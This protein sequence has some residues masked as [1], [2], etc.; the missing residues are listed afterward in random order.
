MRYSQNSRHTGSRGPGSPELEKLAKLCWPLPLAALALAAYVYLSA[1]S[2]PESRLH[3]L[4]QAV[5]ALEVD[6]ARW[7]AAASAQ[8]ASPPDGS[9]TLDAT[10]SALD[11]SRAELRA[12]AS[13]LQLDPAAQQ[14]L[15]TL[16]ANVDRLRAGI[17]QRPRANSAPLLQSIAAAKAQLDRLRA[18]TR[19]HS[20]RLNTLAYLLC[21]AF[22][23]YAL[24]AHL[25]LRRT[26]SDLKQRE[27]ERERSRRRAE[28]SL[29]ESEERLRHV[30]ESVN[31]F[32]WETDPQA[33]FTFVSERCQLVRGYT[34]AQM[35]GQSPYDYIVDDDREQVRAEIAAAVEAHRP[36][37]IE[38]RIRCQSGEV[39]WE[40]ITGTPRFDANGQYL[41]CRGAC[42]DISARKR[43]EQQ[44][45]LMMDS[46]PAAII[47]VDREEVFRQVNNT[48]MHWFP[49]CGLPIGK[50]VATC[51]SAE[52]YA[53]LAEHIRGVLDGQPQSFDAPTQVRG[54]WRILH[55]DYI[56][57]EASGQGV[58]GY[59]GMLTDVT[60][61]RRASQMLARQK[62]MLERAEALSSVGSWRWEVGDDSFSVSPESCRILG[63]PPVERCANA[64]AA[65]LFHP[66]DQPRVR[67]SARDCLKS[68]CEQTLQVRILRHGEQRHLF[69]HFKAERSGDA[70]GRERTTAIAGLMRD[71]TEEKR[72]ER[73]EAR[74][75]DI[76]EQVPGGIYQLHID[77]AGNPQLPYL[78]RGAER[79]LGYPVEVLQQYP[80][81]LFDAVHPD[82]VSRV[83]ASTE[84]SSRELTPFHEQIRMRRKDGG[85]SWIEATGVPARQADGSTLSTGYMQD[86]TERKQL[87]AELE[88]AQQRLHE[89]IESMPGGF[90]LYDADDRLVIWNRAQK[91]I[92]NPTGF[93]YYR[94]M[95][96]EELVRYAVNHPQGYGYF[97]DEAESERFVA[98]RLSGH[99]TA[100]FSQEIRLADGRW[101]WVRE[102]ATREGGVVGIRTDISA[103]KNAEDEL[104]EHRDNL[105]QLV[106]ARS[107][108]LLRAKE[109]AERANQL[110]SEFLA[111][112]SHELRTPM[113]AILS[114]AGMGDKRAARA[115][116][117]KLGHYFRRIGESGERLLALLN[118][119]LDLSKLEA[120]QMHMDFAEENFRN[121]VQT[122]LEEFSALL[123]R[124][125]IQIHCHNRL[126]DAQLR[127]DGIRIQQVVRNLLSNAVKFSPDGGAIDVLLE[128]CGA[129]ADDSG[130]AGQDNLACSVRD[131]GP[132]IPSGE[133]DLVFDEFVQSSNTRTGAGGTGLGLAICRKIVHLHGG[134]IG[135]VNRDG[136]GA[137]FTFCLPRRGPQ[138]EQSGPPPC[139]DADTDADADADAAGCPLRHGD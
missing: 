81:Q 115:E 16:Q 44:M 68:G 35:L 42:E 134:G 2:P 27:R 90:M 121:L 15:Q 107:A 23:G 10:R 9:A 57:H 70:A 88:L 94:G 12:A 93:N 28:A 19:Q 113:H 22:G 79:L 83:R 67:S 101:I 60:E 76:T 20:R 99:R 105:Q 5:H 112:I 100:D 43:A 45:Q 62:Q 3:R 58:I 26:T 21:A 13:D 46:V 98:Q 127:C 84:C 53:M 135:A 31:E 125:D 48:W 17:G 66:D 139:A 71:I 65:A 51:T 86:I 103:Q 14:A 123:S 122:V 96:F 33:R 124:R 29:R 138:P 87:E 37:S 77:T 106:D 129:A 80:N 25:Q 132:G 119:L 49:D 74:L 136:G 54:E 41:G 8:H 117:D 52:R 130:Q 126:R 59:Y 38:R 102:T 30:S 69:I 47:Y 6:I 56:P 72:A 1:A 104:R 89:A 111:N 32:L 50:H 128:E 78:S 109:E 40:R 137:A 39:I 131:R 82:D 118:D 63:L 92:F 85:W 91:D 24:F 114:F 11:K 4:Q 116:R 108:D 97:A 34:A 64:Q 110:K 36:F 61:A 95:P 18:E 120:E 73:I 133:L 75:R 7:S 55:I